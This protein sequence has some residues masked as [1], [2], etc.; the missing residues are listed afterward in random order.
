MVVGNARTRVQ[1]ELKEFKEQL[2]VLLIGMLFVILAADVRLAEISALGRRGLIVVLALMFLVR[3]AVILSSTWGAGLSWRDKTFLAW[4]APRGIVAAAVSSLFDERLSAAGIDGGAEMRAMVF[5]VIAATVVFQGAT[6]EYVA[7]LLGVRRPSGQGYA[8]LGASP[9]GRA[10]ARILAAGGEKVVLID[11]D[12]SKHQMAEGE[13]FRVVFGNALEERVLLS[14]GVESRKAALGV[15]SNAA[16]NLL[17]ARKAREEYGTP[18]SCVALD[19]GTGSVTP[20]MAH[21]VGASVLF[22]DPR[23]LELWSV[24]L[25]RGLALVEPWRRDEAAGAEDDGGDADD[26]Q[27]GEGN[28]G[29]RRETVP[30]V[31][32]EMER[33]AVRDADRGWSLPAEMPHS[34]LP[35]A[36]GRGDRV[37]P[38]DDETRI[39][40]GDVVH[41][42]VF[43]ERAD[44]LRAWLA[45][46]GWSPA[47]LSRPADLAPTAPPAGATP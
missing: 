2:T 8:I 6:A 31:V 44:E 20:E 34:L 3:P 10:L 14:A 41:W 7:R 26:G 21:E 25:R 24:R 39:K 15:L 4:V 13:Q 5:L 23:D 32:R 19:S 30:G 22:G 36:V 9:L 38:L 11:S 17:F 47:P 45:E 28:G 29:E 12:A 46:R 33:E 16:V 40:P 35:L 27:A 37:V 1:R 43:A 18:R 42:L